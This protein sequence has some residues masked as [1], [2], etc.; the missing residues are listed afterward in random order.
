MARNYYYF[1]ILQFCNP[2]LHGLQG[3]H[4]PNLPKLKFLYIF[5][6]CIVSVV[7]PLSLSFLITF[8]FAKFELCHEKTNILHMQF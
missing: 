5:I 8:V 3:L 1:H 6:V 2:G 4:V 7:I